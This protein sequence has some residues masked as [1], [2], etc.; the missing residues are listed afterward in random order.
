MNKII[1]KEEI[2]DKIKR[3]EV[4][5]DLIAKKA[6][7]GQFVI[8]RVDEKG[9][10]IPLTIA[11]IDKEKGAIT[12]IFQEVGTSTTKLGLL[13]EGDEICDIAGPL[14]KPTE[15]ENYGEVCIIVGGVGAA[16]VYWM[17]KAFKEKGNIITTI[18]GA[19]TKNLI[20]L[21]KEMRQISDKLYISTDDGSYGEKGFNTYILERLLENGKKFDLVL[22]AGPIPMMKKVAEI[23]K[24]YNIKTIASLNP[25]MV[26]GTGMC[27]CCRV[28]V[29][30]KTKFACVDGPD[31]D[32]HMVDFDE[33]LKRTSLYKEYEKLSYEKFL[34]SR[35]SDLKK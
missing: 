4:F 19:R 22:T 2:A 27:G 18:I 21:E 34:L 8:L 6:L 16:F 29:G 12:L 9:E 17:G 33:L 13:N 7:P 31:F 32:A 25:I 3:I 35:Q 24:K 23:T 30:G 26:D 15:I 28:S 14:G 5:A 1:K 20:I 11:G 10:R